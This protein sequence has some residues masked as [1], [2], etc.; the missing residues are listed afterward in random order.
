MPSEDRAMTTLPA[1]PRTIAV[2][3]ALGFVASHLLP[4]LEALGATPLLVV[5]PGREA[6]AARAFPGRAIR[7]GSLGES[8]S[9]G[10]TF[11]GADALVHLAGMALTPGFLPA[12][13]A[14]GVRGGVFI[15]SA[16]VHTKLVSASAVAKRRGERAVW[17]A[18]ITG[19]VLRPSMIYG[20]PRDRNLVRLLLWTERWRWVPAPLG[21]RTPQQ[22]VH[23]EDLVQAILASLWRITRGEPVRREYDLGGPEPITFAQMVR[24]CGAAL[25]VKAHIVPLPLAPAHAA[26]RLAQRLRLRFPVRPEQVLRL[27]ESKAVDITPARVDLGFAPRAFEVGIADEVRLLRSQRAAQG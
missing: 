25:G 7:T 21:G 16:G 12:A 6:A 13:L 22:P 4:R 8:G 11:T 27:A 2:T 9:L 18:P 20:T 5:R 24:A 14:A 10:A 3:G 26:A 19:V 1:L 23:V 15:S 17:E